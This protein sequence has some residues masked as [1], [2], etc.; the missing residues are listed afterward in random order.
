MS[1][2]GLVEADV[3]ELTMPIIT[4]TMSTITPAFE[5]KETEGTKVL[6]EESEFDHQTVK[7]N[8][9]REVV[10]ENGISEPTQLVLEASD[11]LVGSTMGEVVGDKVRELDDLDEPTR[12]IEPMET[13]ETRMTLENTEVMEPSTVIET[14]ET[15]DAT[16][17]A[18]EPEETENQETEAK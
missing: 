10:K 16:N 11:T 6:K 13:V 1:E 15:M 4:E 8:N 2:S 9:M 12:A 14:M 5:P 18:V 3:P 17:T 7:S